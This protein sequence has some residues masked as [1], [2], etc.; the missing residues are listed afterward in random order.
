MLLERKSLLVLP[1]AQISNLR[2]TT[3]KLTRVG[4]QEITGS[5]TKAT[6]NKN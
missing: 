4:N 3:H 1:S 6:T 5:I 2:A